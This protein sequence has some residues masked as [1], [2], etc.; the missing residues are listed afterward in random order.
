M[1]SDNKAAPELTIAGPLRVPYGESVDLPDHMITVSDRD[2]PL[3]Y[4]S[5]VLHAVRVNGQLLRV[6]QLGS[7]LI[8]QGDTFSVEDLREG[9]IRLQHRG[10]VSNGPSYLSL[11]ANDGQLSSDIQRLTILVEEASTLQLFVNKIIH[12]NAGKSA[13]LNS[14]VLDF[15]TSSRPNDV[16]IIV[17]GGPSSGSFHVRGGDKRAERFTLSDVKS[18]EVVY[19]HNGDNNASQ[20]FARLLVL[21]GLQRMALLVRIQIQSDARRTPIMITNTEAHVKAGQLLKITPDLLEARSPRLAAANRNQDI[22][23]SLVPRHGNPK[24]GQ[25]IMMVPIPAEG[26]GQGWRN[27]GDGMMSARLYRF[28]QRDIDQGRIYYRSSP[29][30]TSSVSDDVTFEVADSSMPAHSLQDQVFSIRVLQDVEV[31]PQSL[32]TLAPGVRLGMTVF[33]NQIVPISSVHLAYHD[34]DTDPS[35]IVYRITSLLNN[36]EGSVEHENFP[37]RP[38]L[39]FT[40]QDV[41]QGKILYRPPEQ[42]IGTDQMVVSFNFVGKRC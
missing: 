24:H 25:I 20:D 23:Y 19:S 11:Q 10:V 21:D 31:A 29:S 7:V 6:D 14:D 39:Q 34:Q 12:V 32:P 16:I 9:K 3:K 22:I 18:A 35:N 27:L 37:Y 1:S 8:S 26:A 42:E 38:V 36:E 13:Q 2:T 5:V 28:T 17:L 41:D 40:Q 33:E 15:S 4:V 30:L